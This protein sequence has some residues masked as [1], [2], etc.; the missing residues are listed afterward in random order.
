MQEHLSVSEATALVKDCLESS[1]PALWVAGEVSNFVAHASGHYYF[2]LKDETAQLRCVMFRGANRRLRFVPEDGLACG[3]FGTI[4]V[5]ARSG[6]YQLIT[7]RLVPLG[8]GDLALAFERLKERLAAEGL[9]DPARKRALPRFPETVGIVTSPTGAAVRDI[10]RVLRRRWPAI[11]VILQPVRVQ[12]EGAAE[13]IAAGLAALDRCG[14][15]DVVIVG[16]GGGSI[17]DLWAFNEEVTARAI[18]ACR[19]PVISAVGHETDTTIADLVADV[20]APTPSAAAEIAV[21]DVEDVLLIARRSSQRGDIALRR[22]LRELA[23]RLEALRRSRVLASPLDRLRQ[24][25]QRA[26]ELAQRCLRATRAAVAHLGERTSALGLRVEALS[27]T[28]V[29]DR[30][31]A[32]VY[33]EGGRLVRG[34]SGCAPGDAVEIQ[35]GRGRARCRVEEVWPATDPLGREN[36]GG[37]T[38]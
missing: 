31:Y 16:R 11:R 12:G 1:L 20:R 22:R 8:E 4:S 26:D 14:Q 36:G 32:L 37:R 18:A 21:R 25:S 35:F 2:S 34:A 6:Q 10:V 15:A 17:E 30:G 38:K 7:E 24:E 3:A 5:Y 19:T 23:L 27:P 28:R 33:D 13:E 9:F 29:L